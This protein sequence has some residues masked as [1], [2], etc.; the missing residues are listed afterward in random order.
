VRQKAR[1]VLGV[2]EH[3]EFVMPAP[4]WGRAESIRTVLRSLAQARTPLLSGAVADQGSG[5]TGLQWTFTVMLVPCPPARPCST[6][7]CA[8]TDPNGRWS[9]LPSPVHR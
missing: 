3:D 7:P 4:L 2:P 5:R 8:P 6:T 9:P 1:I